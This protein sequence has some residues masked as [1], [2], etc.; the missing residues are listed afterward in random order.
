MNALHFGKTNKNTW[1]VLDPERLTV[2]PKDPANSLSPA[3]TGVNDQ[4]SNCPRK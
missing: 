1:I 4:V 3:S 2:A